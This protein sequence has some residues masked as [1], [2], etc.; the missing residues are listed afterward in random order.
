MAPL[1]WT[2]GRTC[3]TKCATL[4]P[5]GQMLEGTGD[6]EKGHSSLVGQ[7]GL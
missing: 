5:E 7:G 1:G 6:S 3:R 2:V 4:G